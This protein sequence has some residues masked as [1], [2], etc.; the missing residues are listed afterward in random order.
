MN[1]TIETNKDAASLQI[2]SPSHGSIVTHNGY[3]QKEDHYPCDVYI[4]SG[5][6]QEP[7]GA[8]SNFWSWR[9]I[10]KDGSLGEEEHGYGNF[11]KSKTAHSIHTLKS[12]LVL[13]WN[14]SEYKVNKP[15]QGTQE[16]VSKRVAEE[17]IEN[18][19][20]LLKTLKGLIENYNIMPNN[21]YEGANHYTNAVKLIEESKKK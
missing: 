7:S 10:L 1:N 14:G 8:I 4:E 18:I 2:A 13:K 11:S 9:R 12:P 5:Y 16:L 21:G 6:F 15:D 19:D 20:T 17:A 3:M